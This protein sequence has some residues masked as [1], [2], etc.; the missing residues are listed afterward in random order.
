[1]GLLVDGEW[2][3]K[4]EWESDEKGR[5]KRQKST[6]RDWVTTDDSTPYDPEAGRYHLYVSYACPW[7]HRT[8]TVRALRGLD[9]AID[10]SVVDPFMSKEGWGFAP[11]KNGC[12][13]DKLHGHE[14]LREVYTE[15]D[16]EFTGRVTV[17]VLWDRKHE[18]IVNNESSEIIRM[19]DTAF[20]ELARYPEVDLYPPELADD[21]DEVIDAIYQPINN[22]VYRAG[23]AHSQEAYDE[24]ID[25]LFGA[26]DHWDSVLEDQRYLCGDQLTEA[27]VCMFT[28]LFRFDHVYHT[29]F[30]CNVRQI[31]QY[32]NLSGY[33]RELYQ[34]PGVAEISRLDHVTH[35]YYRSHDHIN[36]R[37][38]EARGPEIDFEAPH[39]RDELA[40]GF[41]R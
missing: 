36:P 6:F 24:A 38:I 16:S 13:P 7:A 23:F 15:A 28:T 25:Q 8:L 2:K 5:F 9:E 3:Y 19:F 17:P 14:W 26:L 10:V 40:G 31:Q 30:Q 11:E 29:H 41:S 20:D 18:T 1:M 4:G 32:P 33:L 22:G 34:L 27:D 37:R 21:I 35:H 39:G 12:T